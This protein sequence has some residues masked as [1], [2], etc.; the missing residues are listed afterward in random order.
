MD[1]EKFYRWCAAQPEGRSER[2]ECELVA[3]SPDRLGHART[4][5]AIFIALLAAMAQTRSLCEVFIDSVAVPSGASA[6]LPDLLINCGKPPGAEQMVAP[7][8]VV[9][10]EVLSPSTSAIDTGGRLPLTSISHRSRST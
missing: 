5:Q 7:S 10:A 3:V 8:P 6:Y 1:R 4:K 2:V 9:I